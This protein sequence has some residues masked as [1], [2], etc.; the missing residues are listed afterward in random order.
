MILSIV[1][2]AY[3]EEEAIENICRQT[4]DAREAIIRETPVD[5]VEIIVVSDGSSDRTAERTRQFDEIRLIAY[6]KNRGYGAAIKTGFEASRGHLI[7]FLDADGTC[8][9]LF[10]VDL[11]NLLEENKADIALGSRMGADSEMPKSRKV[12]NIFFRTLIRIIS[13]KPIQD[14]ASG[15]RVI[16]KSSLE[17]LYPLPSGLHFTPAMSCRAALDNDITIVEKPMKYKERIGPSKLGIIRDGLRFF[18][19]IVEVALTYKPFSFFGYLATLCILLA[20]GYGTYPITFY[21]QNGFIEDWMIYRIVFITVMCTVGFNL[22][23]IGMITSRLTSFQN[24]YKNP[25]C[26]YLMEI[27][28]KIVFRK[29]IITAFI[30]FTG[31]VLLNVKTIYEYVSRGT[32]DVHWVFIITG[33]WLV[34]LSSQ[35]ASFAVFDRTVKLL[36]EQ[37]DFLDAYKSKKSVL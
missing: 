4:L 32:I 22:Y 26:N 16:R 34:L 31:A 13:H 5:E 29:P 10:F 27:M 12:G 37:R 33:A 25:R 1:I 3:N 30:C 11:V 17:K 2:P 20:L 23:I 8:N 19:V 15:M 24:P 14:A 9:P 18:R 6:K 35:F 21:L 28:E 36:Q 7:S